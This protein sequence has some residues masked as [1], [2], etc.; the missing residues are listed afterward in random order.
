[1]QLHLT[2]FETLFD[3][4]NVG[5]SV[6]QESSIFLVVLLNQVSAVEADR[7]PNVDPFGNMLFLEERLVTDH[8]F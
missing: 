6:V 8:H 3:V 5:L 1:M 4:G 2:H 7:L